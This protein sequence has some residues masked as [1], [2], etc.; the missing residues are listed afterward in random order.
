MRI[1]ALTMQG[2]STSNRSTGSLDARRNIE[3]KPTDPAPM[4]N[5]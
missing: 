3:A 4:R 5:S 1:V 2:R